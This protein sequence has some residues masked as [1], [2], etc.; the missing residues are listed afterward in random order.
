MFECILEP[1][2]TIFTVTD[3]V[4][5]EAQV[6]RGQEFAIHISK[7][8]M[9]CMV[10]DCFLDQRGVFLGHQLVIDS[11]AVVSQGLS[12]AVI[13]ALAHLQELL[14]VLDC[15]LILLDIVIEHPDGVVSSALIPNLACPSA[16]ERQHLIILKPSLHGN[17]G[18]IVYFLRVESLV[19][20]RFVGALL[21]FD[22][23]AGRVEE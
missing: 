23:A 21:L 18:P 6:N 4:M 14:V 20:L 1:E 5:A 16:S 12:M 3:P 11:D 7:L 8:L 15:L 13:D 9:E 17:E 19:V 2:N 22:E 10:L